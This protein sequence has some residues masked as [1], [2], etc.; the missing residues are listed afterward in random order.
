MGESL[1]DVVGKIERDMQ[2]HPSMDHFSRSMCDETV[3]MRLQ[4]VEGDTPHIVV[5]I[6]GATHIDE[7]YSDYMGLKSLIMCN[8]ALHHVLT[9]RGVSL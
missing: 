9:S 6:D 1:S 4:R 3:E 8:R 5:I 2:L 7:P